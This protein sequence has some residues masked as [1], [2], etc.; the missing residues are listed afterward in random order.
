MKR[1]VTRKAYITLNSVPYIISYTPYTLFIVYNLYCFKNRQQPPPPSSI[2]MPPLAWQN[3]M[4]EVS[5]GGPDDHSPLFHNSCMEPWNNQPPHS[6]KSVDDNWNPMPFPKWQFHLNTT[7]SPKHFGSS[8]SR[9]HH[10]RATSKLDHMLPSSARSGSIFINDSPVESCSVISISSS[11][12]EDLDNTSTN[13]QDSKDVSMLNV[14][15]SSFAAVPLPRTP[16]PMM[17]MASYVENQDTTIPDLKTTHILEQAKNYINNE[18]VSSKQSDHFTAIRPKRS[19]IIPM[20]QQNPPPPTQNNIQLDSTNYVFPSVAGTDQLKNHQKQNS[21]SSVSNNPLYHDL[22]TRPSSDNYQFQR[23]GGHHSPPA[24]QQEIPS[25][26]YHHDTITSSGTRFR[27]K[28]F[29]QNQL[30]SS[31]ST[32]RRQQ[33]HCDF[34][35]IPF[36]RF[37]TSG[38][39]ML[40]TNQRRSRAM[41][42]SSSCCNSSNSFHQQKYHHSAKET[43]CT[44]CYHQPPPIPV[45]QQPLSSTQ[46]HHMQETPLGAVAAGGHYVPFPKAQVPIGGIPSVSHTNSH[47]P[48][49]YH[50]GVPFSTGASGTS[51]ASNN[52]SSFTYFS[53]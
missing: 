6:G 8:S 4:E 33:Q 52:Y 39:P 21:T 38:E 24:W 32:S 34:A 20:L 22:P 47:E 14:R 17:M 27:P 51:S 19:R 13:L 11:S 30:S 44:D 45:H 28:C 25:S 26:S 35:P 9:G 18:S 5:Y 42:L 15:S 49:T 16:S 10:E 29:N 1:R 41:D 53:K 31:T 46:Y 48:S 23:N 36:S 50:R 37:S 12:E 3:A 7:S 43:G 2:P 40:S